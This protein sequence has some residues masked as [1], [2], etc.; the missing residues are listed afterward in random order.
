MIQ[1]SIHGIQCVIPNIYYLGKGYNCK[2]ESVMVWV[3]V[4]SE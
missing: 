2:T 4:C 1:T 3:Q